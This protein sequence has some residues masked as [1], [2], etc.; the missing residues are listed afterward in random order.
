MLSRAAT[1][2]VLARPLDVYEK[3]DGLNVGFAFEGPGR[4]VLLS[5]VYGALPLRAAGS[6]LWRLSS[7]AGRH[8]ARLWAVCGTRFAAFGEWLE[9]AFRV[10][11]PAL[12]GFM[13]FFDLLER[14]T[15]EPVK[16]GRTRLMRTG[17]PVNPRLAHRRFAS[18]EA[19]AALKAAPRFG[20][21]AREGLLLEQGPRRYK[22]V[23]SHYEKPPFASLGRSSNGLRAGAEPRRVRCPW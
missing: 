4:L 8:Q 18:V 21:R 20:A 9:P 7:W 14:A 1:A 16:S 3:L 10:R 6:E 12:E 11:Y 22:L 19:L 15:G 13:V 17:L 5:R 2:R 23:F